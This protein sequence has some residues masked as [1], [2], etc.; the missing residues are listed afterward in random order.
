MIYALF[1]GFCRGLRRPAPAARASRSCGSAFRFGLVNVL[2]LIILLLLKS[3]EMPD[4]RPLL[5][6]SAAA[7]P[8]PFR[9]CC[10]NLFEG[11]FGVVTDLRLL[12]LTGVRHPLIA[13]FEEKAPG[14]YQ[15]VLNVTKLAEAAAQA[16]GANYL[17]VRAERTSTTWAK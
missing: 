7:W 12:E 11:V 16:I 13:Q 8:A 17:L 4:W 1:G 6:P 5:R 10:S 14:S 3:M 15:H 9:T 2:T